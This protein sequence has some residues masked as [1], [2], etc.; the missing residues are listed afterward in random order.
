MKLI[1]TLVL[2]GSISSAAFCEQVEQSV[3]E[4]QRLIR[5]EEK[6]AAKLR[7]QEAKRLG[8]K[9]LSVE[10]NATPAEIRPGILR[11][12]LNRG[13]TLGSDSE[14]QITFWQAVRGASG[15]G[16]QLGAAMAGRGNVRPEQYVRFVFLPA[17]NGTEVR[18]FCGQAE[19]S[20]RSNATIRGEDSPCPQNIDLLEM[21]E[22]IKIAQPPEPGARP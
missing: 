6:K 18:V 17:Q 1:L 15:F 19:T 13:A 4:R 9:P 14:I 3:K 21:L 12:M 16:Y 20:E 5:K 8:V 22:S 11:A 10:F 7:K 2:C